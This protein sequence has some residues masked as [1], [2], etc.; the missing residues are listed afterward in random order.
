MT[1]GSVEGAA[2]HDELRALRRRLNGL[3]AQRTLAF[4][5]TGILLT[6]AA[7]ILLAMR[8][9]AAA[10]TFGTWCAAAIAVTLATYLPWRAY[11]AWLSLDD[12][13]RT[14]DRCSGLEGRLTTLLADPAPGSPLRSL[15]IAQ[16]CAAAPRWQAAVL[17]PRRIAPALLLVP[18]ALTLFAV[19][20]FIVRPPA[21]PTSALPHLDLPN[22]ATLTGA[23][24]SAAS[25]AA[26]SVSGAA[27]QA[28]TTLGQAAAG[29]PR[30]GSQTG[31]PRETTGADGSDATFGSMPGEFAS[32]G[33]GL[34]EKIRRAL[35]TDSEERDTAGDTTGDHR[36]SRDGPAAAGAARAANTSPKPGEG[37]PPQS[38][39]A[40]AKSAEAKSTGA[41]TPTQPDAAR[42]LSSGG[43]S[44]GGTGKAGGGGASESLFANAPGSAAAPPNAAKPMAIKLNTFAAAAPQQAE[45]QRP[46]GA[47]ASA[48]TSGLDS[49]SAPDLA[50]AQAPD[51]ALQKPEVAPEHE[52]FV[53]RI[54]T[55]E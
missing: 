6:A 29:R 12:A 7:L 3:T 40:D 48:T 36:P 20:A 10:F 13:A 31:Q 19:A 17:A 28:E 14:A 39:A 1:S 26:N 34:R 32:G 49:G 41:D 45:P 9:S 46:A 5:L 44:K 4:G 18:A 53:R 33:G 55:R 24:S 8:S 23:T 30:D 22:R 47:V 42:S 51:A 15:L 52:A 16:V 35:G 11:E 37:P 21:R 25:F 2:V 27:D 54:F 43:D 38:A 50:L